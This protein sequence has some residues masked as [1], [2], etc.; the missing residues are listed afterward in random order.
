MASSDYLCIRANKSK[1][2][3]QRPANEVSEQ[4]INNVLKSIQNCNGYPKLRDLASMVPFLTPLQLNAVIRF[5][6]R[7]GTIIIDSDG[8]IIWTRKDN[9]E[10]L[11]TLQEV[12]YISS[13][14]KEYLEK[15]W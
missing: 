12:A 5:L 7:L 11:S 14:F 3:K 15:H 6:E 13:D 10:S 8:Y 9:S 2:G 1:K 4:D